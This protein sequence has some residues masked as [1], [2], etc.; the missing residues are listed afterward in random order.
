[1]NQNE[2]DDLRLKQLLDDWKVREPLPRRFQERVWQR[3][4]AAESRKTGGQA[5]RW[6]DWLAILFARPAFV[7]ACAAL[8][9]VAGLATGLWRANH[10]SARWNNEL[11]HRYV[12]SVDPYAR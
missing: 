3:I 9:L 4:E 7:T 8:L 11:A 1:M 6:T 10:D 5:T 2:K 12:A